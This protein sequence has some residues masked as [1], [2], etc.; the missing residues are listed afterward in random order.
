MLRSRSGSAI[1]LRI[2]LFVAAS[3]QDAISV[4]AHLFPVQKQKMYLHA[5]VPVSLPHCGEAG[6]PGK[7]KGLVS[8]R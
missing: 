5:R 3:C 7:A 6:K 2:L 1:V 8:R 4:W